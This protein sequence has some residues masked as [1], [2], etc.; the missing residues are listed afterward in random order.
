M[1]NKA[2]GSFPYEVEEQPVVRLKSGWV[3]HKAWSKEVGRKPL[4]VFLYTLAQGE[5]LETSPALNFVQRLKTLRH[6]YVLPYVD[7]VTIE[8]KSQFAIVTERVQPL[9]QLLPKLRKNVSQMSW[10]L[11]QVL[12]V[13][14]FL[15]KSSL[16][17]CN[18]TVDTI[19]VDRSGDW[20]VGGFE[21]T[22]S[23][24]DLGNSN[25]LRMLQNSIPEQALPPEFAR[26]ELI[27]QLPSG[28]MDAWLAGCLIFSLF[29]KEPFTQK[30]QLKQVHLLPP[31]LKDEYTRLLTANPG[32]R[33]TAE[34][35]L[36]SKYFKSPLVE[37]CL[38][39]EEINVRDGKEK[40]RFFVNLSSQ[41]DSFPATVCKLKI[42]PHLVGALDYGGATGAPIGV[43]MSPLLQICKML[44]TAEFNE[45]VADSVPKW[46]KINDRG[47][48]TNLLS[49][50]KNYLQHLTDAQVNDV[51]Y[52]A[53]LQSFV[54]Q[55]PAMRLLGIKTM[56][57]IAPK[58]KTSH[59]ESSLLRHLAKLQVDPEPSIRTNT[60][61]LLGNLA[62]LLPQMTREKVLYSAFGR[63]LRDQFPPSRKAALNAFCHTKD[64]FSIRDTATKVLPAISFLTVDPNAEVRALALEGLELFAAK[65]VGG[66]PLIE[67][68]QLDIQKSGRPVPLGTGIGVSAT[69]GE[70]PSVLGWAIGKFF[71]ATGRNAPASSST[72]T[73]P[74]GA[75]NQNSRPTTSTEATEEG[76]SE[77]EN[78]EWADAP[79]AS[80]P[81][82]VQTAPSS[83]PSVLRTHN[84][85]NPSPNQFSQ[86]PPSLASAAVPS[87][88]SSHASPSDGWD[89]DDE[90]DWGNDVTYVDTAPKPKS[91]P[92]AAAMTPSSSRK[93]GGRSLGGGV[94]SSPSPTP[95]ASKAAPKVTGWEDTWDDF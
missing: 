48:R 44:D 78:E 88:V 45:H 70:A 39:L 5:S 76:W 92:S 28:A 65:L 81:P 87:T 4:S 14:A 71:S 16:V 56:L 7:G 68:Q 17:H 62:P 94:A 31:E 73:A 53:V 1:G 29:A 32:R 85:S 34:D 23:Q 86:P 84:P 37:T 13:L 6:P 89:D 77:D 61:I 33:G 19:F 35:T 20:K 27:P 52:P 95:P 43:V 74:N 69:D 24:T 40:E 75:S 21:S 36:R 60:T 90:D 57:L 30:Q 9:S 2:S 66:Q 12:T 18:V 15:A 41:L 25:V 22:V 67:A 3:M 59:Q 83:S 63:A 50:L 46:F 64:F 55:L 26:P 51:V 72:P 49:N 80:L 47:L 42:L 82:P 79:V 54:D 8:A 91:K 38:F 11:Y 58:V 10:G 93:L